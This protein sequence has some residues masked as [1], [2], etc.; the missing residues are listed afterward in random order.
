MKV[1][2]IDHVGIMVA[3]LEAAIRFY[4]ETFGLAAGPI[5]TREQPPIRRCCIRV[6]ESELEL[7]EARDPEQT[8]MHFLP[9]RGPGIYH[10][11]LRVEDVDGTAAELRTQGVPLVD[12][13]REGEDMRIQYL[14]PDAAQGTMIELVTRRHGE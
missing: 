12:G 8:M 6:G 13:V 11:G 2:R 5:Q 10:V 3:D 14:H 9:H 4:T 1:T 7:I